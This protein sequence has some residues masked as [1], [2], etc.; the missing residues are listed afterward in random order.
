M[1]RRH[2]CLCGPFRHRRRAA[3]ASAG[4]RVRG[5]APA[6]GNRRRPGSA[7]LHRRR[8]RHRPALAARAWPP[9][10]ALCPHR[11]GPARRGKPDPQT[12]TLRRPVSGQRSPATASTRTHQ[13]RGKSS[14]TAISAPGTPS[15]GTGYR[16]RSSTG[17]P[18]SPSTRWPTWPH[19]HGPSCRSHHPISFPRQ[20]ST[21]SPTYRD[22]CTCSWTPYG[23]TDRKAILTAL[24]RCKLDEPEPL[25]W[26]QGISADL[27]R[28][29]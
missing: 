19:R 15:T 7:D 23:L 26:L 28:A 4:S 20:D 27:A 3:G 1:A 18:P 21:R 9:A 24:Q 25:R 16:W 17:T 13:R 8:C 14:P 5:L 10:P 6:A 11:S 22:G 12:C 29:L 2:G